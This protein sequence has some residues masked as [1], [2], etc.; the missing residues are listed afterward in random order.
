MMCRREVSWSKVEK[1]RLEIEVS[2]I[3]FMNVWIPHPQLYVAHGQQVSR[4]PRPFGWK[5]GQCVAVM[6]PVMTPQDQKVARK[7]TP[8]K[9][10][11][12]GWTPA[13]LRWTTG[14]PQAMGFTPS[15]SLPFTSV[16]DLNEGS[17]ALWNWWMILLG[18]LFGF[19]LEANLVS[20]VKC[21][22][23][24]LIAH[25]RKDRQNDS[26]LFRSL[27]YSLSGKKLKIKKIIWNIYTY[28]ES[29]RCTVGIKAK[30]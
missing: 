15:F 25:I 12:G 7:P 11:D 23:P 1:G 16:V 5:W 14:P 13:F 22:P 27:F 29:L 8:G 19:F 24:I 26:H 3:F 2:L 28:M 6:A 17:K 30:L 20:P 18:V 10:R 21:Q 4:T 9:G